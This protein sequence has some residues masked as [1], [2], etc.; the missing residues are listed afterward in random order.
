MSQ[1]HRTDPRIARGSGCSAEERGRIRGVLGALASFVVLG[2][3]V[4]TPPASAAR[5]TWLHVVQ[6]ELTCLGLASPE[7]R[8]A[9]APVLLSEDAT[10]EAWLARMNRSA[11]AS[12]DRFAYLTML[13]VLAQMADTG[14]DQSLRIALLSQ[15]ITTAAPTA[16]GTERFFTQVRRCGV[17]TLVASALALGDRAAASRSASLLLD[18]YR[19]SLTSG[20]GADGASY[21]DLPL[22]EALREL[23]PGRE[24]GVLEPY[25]AFLVARAERVAP[26]QPARASRLHTEAASAAMALGQLERAN[27]LATEAIKRSPHTPLRALWDLFP[28]TWDYFHATQGSESAATVAYGMMEKLPAP[29]RFHDTRLTYEVHRRLASSAELRID[30]EG[31]VSHHQLALRGLLDT[32]R[33]RLSIPTMRRGFAELLIHEAPYFVASLADRTWALDAL[34]SYRENVETLLDQ[35]EILFG[36]AVR[37]RLLLGAK[38]DGVLMR[39]SELHEALPDQRDAIT[40]LTF[41]AGQLRAYSPVA[42][43]SVA[44]SARGEALPEERRSAVDRFLRTQTRYSD[45]LARIRGYLGE[46]EAAMQSGRIG[47]TFLLLDVMYEETTRSFERYIAVVRQD[48]PG[49]APFLTANPLSIA[50]ARD[51]LRPGEAL[52]TTVSS[53]KRLFV[54]AVSDGN[55]AF[56]SVDVG[57]TEVQRTVQAVRKSL[58]VR[59]TEGKIELLPYNAA[60]AHELY[61]WTLGPIVN[62]VA[63]AGHVFWYGHGAL[64]TVP[65]GILVTSVPARPRA[66][67][68]EDLA[69]VAWLA[70]AFPISVLTDAALLRLLRDRPRSPAREPAFVGIGA[71]LLSAQDLRR[72]HAASDALAGPV[73][74]KDIAALPKLPEAAEELRTLAALFDEDRTR[75]LLGPAASEEALADAGLDEATVV[76]FATHGFVA[77]QVAGVSE[78]SL[79]LAA[80]REPGAEQDGFL[81][82]SEITALDLDA[83]LVILSACNT[84]SP[85]RR[86]DAETFTGLARGFFLAGAHSLLVSHWSVLS[87]AAG[88]ISEGV[89]SR[90]RTGMP[91]AESLR[92]T[93]GEIRT[94]G[95]AIRA[96]PSYWAPFVFVGD[97]AVGLRPGPGARAGT[98]RDER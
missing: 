3:L 2:V 39:L 24:P 75:L 93:M 43:S 64:G 21:E 78:P 97:G 8:A 56:R 50:E 15:I 1:N 23:V 61:T 72:R 70:D 38:I 60:A 59:V 33:Q 47:R 83:E 79:L 7:E 44:G 77:G 86:P 57:R 98:A 69:R 52:V 35:G 34:T 91:L 22:I 92:V 25:I 48:L 14:N 31:S 13:A 19:A 37:D 12:N 40:D 88:E 49:L 54:W 30:V 45:T 74:R 51:L 4:G 16:P 20:P 95:D 87:S 26:S 85:E 11:G 76:A 82:A 63:G 73:G 41:R 6:E 17:A 96:H 10:K 67:S 55:A 62:E 66:E 32:N 65:P 29:E 89:V 84:A 36:P 9:F 58:A 5:R 81:T 46:E 80:P 28:V 42:L 94:A 27:R 71:P 18:A 68:P 53:E 90:A